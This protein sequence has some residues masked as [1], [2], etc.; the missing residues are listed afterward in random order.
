MQDRLMDDL[1][2]STIQYPTAQDYIHDDPVV[3]FNL[4]VKR[5]S[6]ISLIPSLQT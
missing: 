5:N 6:I 3:F 1:D 4:E 2:S